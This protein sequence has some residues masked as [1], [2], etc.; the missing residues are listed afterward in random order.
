MNI[1]IVDDSRTMRQLLC[2]AVKR[3][4]LSTAI[5]AT[6][7]AD[8]LKKLSCQRI[9]LILADVNMPVMDGFELVSVIRK[10]AL[11]KEIPIIMI[12][13]QGAKEDEQKALEIGANAYLTKPVHTHELIRLVSNFL[14]P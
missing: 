4:P 12:T 7:G 13:T 9:D 10:N 3:I 11:Y 5:E 6:N 8:A 2:F 1:L 14:S